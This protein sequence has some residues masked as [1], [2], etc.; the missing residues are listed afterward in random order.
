[1]DQAIGERVADIARREINNHACGP[2]KVD[3]GGYFSSCVHH[4]AHEEW[5]ADFARWV[6][7]QAQ[8]LNTDKLT[9]AAA[10]FAKYGAV[11]HGNPNVGD[12]VLFGYDGVSFAKHVAIV[13]S[14]LPGGKIV[15]IGGNEGPSD[16]TSRVTKD[17]PYDGAFNSFDPLAPNGPLSG[18]VS[19]VEDDMPF[20]KQEIL[21]L[22]QQGVA[23]ELA[24]GN[25]KNE[26]VGLV[27]QGVA[28]ELTAALGTTGVTAAQGAKAAVDADTAL[29][30]IAQ[31]L[32]ALTAQVTAL[33]AAAPSTT[34]TG[35]GAGTGA[36]A[37]TGD[38]A[39]TGQPA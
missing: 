4:Q 37:G 12:A 10:S 18:Y 34:G 11:R 15:T 36:A 26:I 7:A 16:D 5:C 1:V 29:A 8:A 24:A 2:N 33:A 21:D 20:T 25:T 23:A 6:W 14:V 38:M 35:Q 39:G 27:K 22:V 32:T 3:G 17:G 9:P 30:A 28:A 31:Q 19:P 13:V